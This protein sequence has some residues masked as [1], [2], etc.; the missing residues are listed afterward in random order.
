MRI[1]E[2]I[3]NRGVVTCH[4]YYIIRHKIYI[5][6]EL[7]VDRVGRVHTLIKYNIRKTQTPHKR[8]GVTWQ[9]GHLSIQMQFSRSL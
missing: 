4:H 7:S 8:N 5:I 2:T 1:S 3:E 6:K 9:A